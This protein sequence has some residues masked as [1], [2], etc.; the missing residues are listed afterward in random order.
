MPEIVT[1]ETT[2]PSLLS[3]VRNLSDHAAWREFDEKYR[4]LILRYCQRKGLQRS[5]AED[6]RQMVMLNLARH[7]RKFTYRPERGRFRDYMGRVVQNAIHRFFRSPRPENRGLDADVVAG[8]ADEDGERDEA[9][10]AEWMLHHYRMAMSNVR[11]T[12]E[13]KSIEVFERLLAGESPDEVATSL[14]MKRDAVHK[15]KQRMRNRL[16][17][18][19]A[20]QILDEDGAEDE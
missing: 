13:P 2:R 14:G 4:D 7:L 18:L 6:V 12:A 20:E 15:V 16:R 11:R 19:V 3:R 9:W 17:D 5:D 1:H 8:L 10:E